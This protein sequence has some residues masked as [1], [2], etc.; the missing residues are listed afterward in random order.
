MDVFNPFAKNEKK[1]KKKTKNKLQKRKKE[2]KGF[3]AEIPFIFFSTL[4]Y[5]LL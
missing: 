3:I 2:K 1:R 4:L 5:V